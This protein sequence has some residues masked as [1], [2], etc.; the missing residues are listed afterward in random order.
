MPRLSQPV[1]SLLHRKVSKAAQ[2]SSPPP[3]NGPLVHPPSQTS[4]RFAG[5]SY[6]LSAIGAT[7]GAIWSVDLPSPMPVHSPNSTIYQLYES[8]MCGYFTALPRLRIVWFSTFRYILAL[9]VVGCVL[10]V[11]L[12]PAHSIDLLPLFRRELSPLWDL[13]IFK[14]VLSAAINNN[15]IQKVR[16]RVYNVKILIKYRSSQLS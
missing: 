5:L 11:A 3:P 12:C 9:D 13:K 16:G 8:S 14:Q 2:S 7:A 1:G 6:Q 10:L 4:Q 15:R